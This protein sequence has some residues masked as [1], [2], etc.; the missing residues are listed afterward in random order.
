MPTHTHY[1]GPHYASAGASYPVSPPDSSS[2][3]ASGYPEDDYS[4]YGMQ[5]QSFYESPATHASPS[6][7]MKNPHQSLS[8]SS[9]K[10]QQ[11]ASQMGAYAQQG[12]DLSVG[13]STYKSLGITDYSAQDMSRGSPASSFYSPQ[14]GQQGAP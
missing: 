1:K 3:G 10:S 5:S 4:K 11:Q 12:S 7:G 9:S 13:A 6:M 8:S 2:L 14:F